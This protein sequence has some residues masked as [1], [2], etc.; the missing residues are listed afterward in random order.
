MS[1]RRF[2]LVLF[3]TSLVVFSFWLMW[4]TLNYDPS[5]GSILVASKYW[6][7]FGNTLPL[8]RSFSFG[9]NWPVQHPLFPGEPIRYHFLFYALVGLLE[10]AGLRFD[11]ALNLPSAL[12][13]FSLCMM[14]YALAKRLF[15]RTGI[16]VLSVIFFLFNGSLSFLDYFSAN[17]PSFASFKQIISNSSFPSFGPWNGSQIAAFWNLN[18]YTNQRH[19][20][21]SFAL[22]LAIIYILYTENKQLARLTGFILGLLLLLNQAAFVISL[23]FIGLFFFYRPSLRKTLIISASGFIPWLIFFLAYFK[24]SAFILFRPF[25]LLSPP[26]SI[27]AVFRYWFLNFGLHLLFIPAGIL[28]APAKLRPLA[29]P[30][31][32]IFILANLLQFSPDIINNHKFFNFFLIVGSMFSAALVV[33]FKKWA[34]VLICMLTFGGLIDFFP[35]KNDYYHRLPDYQHN[36]DIQFFLKFTSPDSVILNSTW[37]YHPASLAG[38][39]IFNGYPYFTWSYGYDQVLREQQTQ[40]IYQASTPEIACHLLQKYHISYVELNNR[41]ESYLQPNLSLWQNYFSPLYSNPVSGVSIYN[42]SDSCP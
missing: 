28:L 6:S 2:A 17:P 41:P 39:R 40:E 19:L 22:V 18:I 10:K 33:R 35:L 36:P 29:I 12:G 32:F 24:T 16:A 34:L 38:R 11:Y 42:I 25:F 9:H 21:L 23:P 1:V 3:F 15:V 5:T 14:I 31:F 37:F 8:V 26:F 30:L 4:H 13:F 27:D 20:S 7:D